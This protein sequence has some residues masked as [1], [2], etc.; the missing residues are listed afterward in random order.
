ML[1]PS[2]GSY[3]LQPHGLSPSRHLCQLDSLGKNTRSR[4]PFPTPGDLPDPEID[5]LCLTSPALAGKFFATKE[6]LFL[7]ETEKREMGQ[8]Q[9]EKEG[10]VWL[11]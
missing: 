11:Q 5:P 6:A 9:S 4:L 10:S 1:S 3:S 2:V 7:N 8:Y